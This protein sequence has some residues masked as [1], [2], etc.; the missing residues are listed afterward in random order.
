MQ[1]QRTHTRGPRR[2]T[3]DDVRASIN[4]AWDLVVVQPG[5]APEQRK[6]WTELD[7]VEAALT[8]LRGRG[9][10]VSQWAICQVLAVLVADGFFLRR[11]IEGLYWLHGDVTLED[12]AMLDALDEVAGRQRRQRRV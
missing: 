6:T 3:H 7:L 12:R 4:A 5:V 11:A 10:N 2:A 8:W 1:E 9:F